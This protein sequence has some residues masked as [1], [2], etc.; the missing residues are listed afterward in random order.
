MPR[1]S[2]RPDFQRAGSHESIGPV[3]NHGN[4]SNSQDMDDEY[5]QPAPASPKPVP[6]V[7]Q[8]QVN[9]APVDDYSYVKRSCRK[10]VNYNMNHHPCDEQLLEFDAELL[11][12]RKKARSVR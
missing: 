2:N 4:F 5:E 1:S 3:E 9:P 8:Q 11:T 6:V 12:P 10:P 7:V